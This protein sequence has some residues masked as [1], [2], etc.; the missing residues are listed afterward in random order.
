MPLPR[1]DGA[2]S[3]SSPPELQ[4]Q[5]QQP[6]RP[7]FEL[8]PHTEPRCKVF[9][10]REQQDSS[11]YVSF[12]VPRRPIAT[13]EQ[14]LHHLHQMVFQQA[15]SARLFRTSRLNEPPFFAASVSDDSLTS[16]V[17]SFVLV[18]Q[19]LEGG[20]LVALRA[21]LTEVGGEALTEGARGAVPELPRSVVFGV[22]WA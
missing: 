7:V 10:D 9:V 15:L 20:T 17:D 13:P 11:V 16:S 12:K 2:S 14:F 21:L 19:A 1:G 8:V 3:S 4:Q 18:A 5:Q 6:E 22:A